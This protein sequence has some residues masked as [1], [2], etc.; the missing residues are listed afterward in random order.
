LR[1]TPP[2]PS[3]ANVAVVVAHPDDEWLWAGGTLLLHRE[4]QCH[5]VA[6]CRAGDLD[7]EP[8]FRKAVSCLG[9]SSAIADLDDGPEQCPLQESE[10]QACILSLL[11]QTSLDVLLTHSPFGEYTRH[12]RHE[13]TARAVAALWRNGALNLA[14]LWMFAYEDGG[15]AYLP[16]AIGDADTVVELPDAE[17]GEKYRVITEVYGFHA[18]SWEART[19]PRVEG[20]WRFGNP[21]E[22]D[23]WMQQRGRP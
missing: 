18:D 11:P 13:E 3:D 22:Y 2:K 14:E 9:A 16:R 6:L 21:G 12:R 4:W 8:K 19:T 10:I 17:W 23:N 5:V 20:F 15:K 1:R 7:R